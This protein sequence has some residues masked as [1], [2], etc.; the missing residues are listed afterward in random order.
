MAEDVSMLGHG[1]HCLKGNAFFTLLL[2]YIIAFSPAVT[3][4]ECSSQTDVGQLRI[5]SDN[6]N[7]D[8]TQ[9]VADAEGNRFKRD[10]RPARFDDFYQTCIVPKLESI[11]IEE[12]SAQQSSKLFDLLMSV[13]FVTKNPEI[14]DSFY[15]IFDSKITQ[16]HDIHSEL[17]I[18]Y[19]A[20]LMARDMA[21]ARRLRSEHED[22]A[23][24]LIWPLME[25]Q[26]FTGRTRIQINENQQVLER[27]SFSFPSGGFIVISASTGCY[28]SNQFVQ[29]VN[30]SPEM[31]QIFRQHGLFLS[32]Q[33]AGFYLDEDREFN[34]TSE[35]LALN[36]SYSDREWPEIQWWGTPVLYF[37]LDGKLKR[38]IAGWPE[39]GREDELRDALAAVGLLN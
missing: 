29:W 11:D 35:P 38:Q 24:P 15:Q 16:G 31:Q 36:F 2:L 4:F 25:K 39:G 33:T 21:G 18:L 27:K 12:L 34:R 32:S 28:F 23:L 1:Y 26:V 3:G 19:K 22:A 8:D 13:Y 5:E 6:L 7:Y 37:Y 14:L 20:L 30:R 17:H 10:L 9:I